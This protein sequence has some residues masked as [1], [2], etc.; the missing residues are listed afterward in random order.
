LRPSNNRKRAE[1]VIW[2]EDGFIVVEIKARR[3]ADGAR[4][5]LRL[6]QTYA[7]ELSK[8]GMTE[9]IEQIDAT[10]SDILSGQI[11]CR[12]V[13]PV[14][15]VGSLIVISEEAPLNLIAESV[16]TKVLPVTATRDGI[17]RLMPQIISLQELET[18]DQWDGGRLLDVLKEK[19]RDK[20]TGVESLR[21]YRQLKRHS[22]VDSSVQAEFRDGILAMVDTWRSPSGQQ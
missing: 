15:L 8:R 3:V 22:L 9:A 16:L 12:C 5:Q 17:L 4:Y 19:M 13:R 20:S 10:I 21:T 11:P 2:Y 18:L 1:G 6:D 7:E 14:R